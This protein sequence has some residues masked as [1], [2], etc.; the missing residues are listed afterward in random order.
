MAGL[1][2]ALTAWAE[3]EADRLL[4]AWGRLDPTRR[5]EVAATAR[6]AGEQAARRVAAELG[7]LLA[8]DPADQRATPWR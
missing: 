2:P 3:R 6:V 5:P 8:L 7:A 1:G 4:S